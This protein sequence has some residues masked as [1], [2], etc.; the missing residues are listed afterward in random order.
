VEFDL[1]WSCVSSVSIPKEEKPGEM[2]TI[3][4][5]DRTS[6]RAKAA[7]AASYRKTSAAARAY[8]EGPERS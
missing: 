6:K 5:G 2:I 7:A 3:R 4:V 8:G 1:P